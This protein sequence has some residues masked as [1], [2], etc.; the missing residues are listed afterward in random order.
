VRRFNLS[1]HA[2]KI[3]LTQVINKVNPKHLVL[4]HGSMNALHE[5][6]RT[7]DLEDK[8]IIHIPDVGEPIEY[9]RIPGHISQNRLARI[10]SP[11]EFEVSIEAEVSGAWLRI[12]EDVLTDPR[13][14]KLGSSGLLNAKW[15]GG[16][17]ILHTLN[18]QKVAIEKARSTGEDCCAVCE[19][20]A[21]GK[22]DCPDSPLFT[23][24]VDPSAKCFEFQRDA[25]YTTPPTNPLDFEL[26]ASLEDVVE[27]ADEGNSESD[28]HLASPPVDLAFSDLQEEYYGQPPSSTSCS[29]ETTNNIHAVAHSQDANAEQ[30]RILH[31]QLAETQMQL[32]QMQQLLEQCQ[33]ALA[34]TREPEAFDAGEA[35]PVVENSSN[36]LQVN[37]DS[38][39]AL[40]SRFLL[41]LK[42]AL[43]K[44]ANLLINQFIAELES[45]PDLDNDSFRDLK[46]A[47]ITCA[48]NA[49]ILTIKPP[50]RKS[51]TRLINKFVAYLNEQL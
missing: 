29:D 6:A 40:Q 10:E 2:D 45:V 32:H 46:S 36:A 39:T 28:N 37:R 19:S 33:Q 20:F 4:I 23:L 9:G 51:A 25:S 15:L 50:D 18:N 31:A 43:R 48:R 1:A 34:S 7:G 47:S 12:P 17:L 38:L 41:T 44:E 21:R 27:V 16:S 35:P 42:P 13:W 3:G 24:T 11:Q 26:S 30:V 5:L 49:F 8:Y 14:E 22:C